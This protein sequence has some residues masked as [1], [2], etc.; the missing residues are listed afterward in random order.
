[1]HTA[2]LPS[3]QLF[4]SFLSSISLVT[5]KL[6]AENKAAFYSCEVKPLPRI[7]FNST[8]LS[9]NYTLALVPHTA[10][11][12]I[13]FPRAMGF[14]SPWSGPHYIQR[15]NCFFAITIVVAGW[16][17]DSLMLLFYWGVFA[18][19]PDQ[20]NGGGGQCRR[21]VS[22]IRGRMVPSVAM[23]GFFQGITTLSPM[24]GVSRPI[25]HQCAGNEGRR[26][27][28]DAPHHSHSK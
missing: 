17:A 25:D 12:L 28:G 27:T 20:V 18:K 2:Q 6:R 9:N 8:A 5:V 4:A 19:T 21:D 22:A 16:S 7:S 11:A 3:W 10:A 23:Q 26:S 1:M 14:S 13:F 15:R 24:L